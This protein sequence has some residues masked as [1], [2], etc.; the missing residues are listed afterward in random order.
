MVFCVAGLLLLLRVPKN[1]A[2]EEVLTAEA[3]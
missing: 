2:S 3:E 1:T